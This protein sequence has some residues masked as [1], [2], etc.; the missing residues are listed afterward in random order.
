ML[1]SLQ[2]DRNRILS[3]AAI[4]LC[5]VGVSLVA[6]ALE[7]S[8]ATEMAPTP[9][10]TS[11][12]SGLS[13]QALLYLL[14]NAILS[15]FGISFGGETPRMPGTSVTAVIELLQ[16]VY[17]YRFLLICLVVVTVL[18]IGIRHR[19]RIGS[20]TVRPPSDESTKQ[21]RT[22]P[23][24][25]WA[26]AA[27]SDAIA[28]AWIEMIQ[29]VEVNDPHARTLREWEIAAIEAGFNP[30]AVQTIT[31]T[32]AEVRYGTVDVTPERRT[33]VQEAL[34]ELP[35]EHMVTDE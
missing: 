23:T 16:L 14:L 11:S 1:G 26:M 31:E 4:C 15:L 29:N 7:S 33:R 9:P 5:T 10:A 6:T 25:D 17:R 13:L 24:D 12:G 19:P 20:T 34:T 8:L 21:S 27:P 18:G 2:I 22:R 30:V 32:F 3:A 35:S 28:H